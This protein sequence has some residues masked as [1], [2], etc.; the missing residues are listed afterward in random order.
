M[1]PKVADL[2]D[3]AYSTPFRDSSLQR[4]S[5]LQPIEEITPEWAWGKSTGKGVKVAVIDSGVEAAHPAVGHVEGYVKIEQDVDRTLKVDTEPHEDCYGHGTAC[6]GIIRSLAPEC[7]IY[8]V[9]VLGPMLTGR[10]AVLAEG[11]RWCIAN[12][13]HVVNM[14]LTT[15]KKEFFGIL[16]ELADEAYFRNIMLVTAANNIPVPSFPAVFASVFSVASH[17]ENDPE[18]FF[19]NPSPPVEFGAYGIGVRVAWR[20]GGYLTSTGNS[21]AAPHITGMIARILANHP[22]LT[23]FQVKFILRA[24]A[25][26]VRGALASPRP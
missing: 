10:G 7:E 22:G 23:P 15:Q 8:S 20:G 12:G 2:P 3:P 6:T 19:Y 9:R 26:N 1:S 5:A 17:D 14:S 13:M 11:I 21:F 25:A 16:H 18:L 24:L 4:L